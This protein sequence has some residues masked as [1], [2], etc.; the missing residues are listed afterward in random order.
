M[1]IG[2]SETINGERQSTGNVVEAVI[3]TT[4]NS[5]TFSDFSAM[6]MVVAWA[7]CA[8]LDEVVYVAGGIA[9]EPNFNDNVFNFGG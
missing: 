8:R 1:L 3:D 9:L 6:P 2:G 4:D 7:A 5:F